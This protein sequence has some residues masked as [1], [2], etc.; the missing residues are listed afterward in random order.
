MEPVSDDLIN[1]TGISSLVNKDYVD[2]SINFDDIE[3]LLEASTRVDEHDDVK[4]E[5]IV[6]S[7]VE[8]M[9]SPI[10]EIP[11]LS[12]DDLTQTFEKTFSNYKEHVSEPTSL[13]PQPEDDDIIAMKEEID[14]ILMAIEES[15]PGITDQHRYILDQCN[16]HN[17]IKPKLEF[18]RRRY[19][20]V[21]SQ[22]LGK[23]LILSGVALMES[24]FDGKRE[25]GSYKPDLTGWSNTVR[26][27]VRRLQNETATVI[28]EIMDSYRLGPWFRLGIELV[29]SAIL[30][31]R[32]R[33]TQYGQK[34]YNPDMMSEAFNDL[35]SYDK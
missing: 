7:F 21:R 18:L 8:E 10:E 17:I 19:N 33:K 27:K 15:Y 28:S 2:D 13:P 6:Q 26:P 34:G 9:E 12:T 35:N 11:A 20:R 3:K 5:D 22:S 1:L 31:S 29:P 14:D 25:F 4:P 23:E 32:M 16:D 30:Y 24:L